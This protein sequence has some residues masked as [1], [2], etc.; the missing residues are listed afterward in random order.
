MRGAAAAADIRHDPQN[1]LQ[2]DAFAAENV[3]MSD[4][5]ALHGKD[6]PGGDIAHID[7]VHDEIEIQ[8]KSR[9]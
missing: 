8:L 9:G 5:S 6:Q 2:R 1:L 3:A 4:L 7:E